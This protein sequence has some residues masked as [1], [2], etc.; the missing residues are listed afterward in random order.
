M[1]SDL[2]YE[3]WMTAFATRLGAPIA[4]EVLFAHKVT[5]DAELDDATFGL[6]CQR[7]Y[8]D[9]DGFRFKALP[10]PAEFVAAVRPKATTDADAHEAF[11][12]ILHSRAR[13]S[14][15][16]RRGGP[17]LRAYQAV[18]GFFAF[19]GLLEQDEPHLRRRFVD[20]YRD[21]AESV[22]HAEGLALVAG[23]AHPVTQLARRVADG[24]GRLPGNAGPRLLPGER[25]P[26]A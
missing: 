24:M 9:F 15:A 10:S 22:A 13:T 12:A 21:V 17:T 19:S 16:E 7:L 1:I 8:R 25:E 3:N 4:R 5:L 11:T 18:G 20:A 14:E 6:A 23:E 26:A 2:L